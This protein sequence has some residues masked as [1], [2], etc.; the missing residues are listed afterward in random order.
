MN[1]RRGSRHFDRLLV[2]PSLIAGLRASAPDALVS[3]GNNMNWT[4]ALAFQL[5]RLGD[6]RLV[7]KITNPVISA[8]DGALRRL[9]RRLRYRHAFAQAAAVLTLCD[10]EA[11]LLAAAFPSAAARIRSVINPYVTPKMLVP[12][13]EAKGERDIVVSIG[14]L[15]PQKQFDL[16]IRAFARV[17][18]PVASW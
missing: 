12:H 6:A 3:T 13:D 15:A 18:P 9:Y 14:R 8:K 16:L 17:R 4:T 1:Q 10:R 7:L 5:A 11:A 2:L